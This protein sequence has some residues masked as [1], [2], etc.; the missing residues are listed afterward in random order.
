MQLTKHCCS[1]NSSLT[2]GHVFLRLT[3]VLGKLKMFC[4]LLSG[5]RDSAALVSILLQF[6][7][8]IVGEILR[9]LMPVTII[10]QSCSGGRLLLTLLSKHVK[11]QKWC[12]D[13]SDALT[14]VIFSSSA[15]FHFENTSEKCWKERS[16]CFLRF[17]VLHIAARNLRFQRHSQLLCLGKI[18]WKQRR[19]SFHAFLNWFD[20]PPFGFIK[21]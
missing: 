16:N 9:T 11:T 18:A 12:F 15:E 1:G 8:L 7:V 19:H 20:V 13:K 4:S 2:L 17:Y 5:D 3:K 6:S 21:F 14:K 10:W